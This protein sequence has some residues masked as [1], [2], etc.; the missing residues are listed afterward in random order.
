MDKQRKWIDVLWWVGLY[1]FWIIVFQK[2]AFALSRTVTVQF[3]YLLFIAANFYFNIYFT[4]PRFLYRKKYISFGFALAAGIIVA[5]LLRVPLAMFLNWNYFLVGLAQ[6][7]PGGLFLDSILNIFIW[8]AFIVSAKLVID[9]FRFQ[10]YVDKMEQERLTTELAFLNAQ[11]NPHFLFNS[12]NSIYGHIDKNN[13]S[14]RNMLL[15]FS[16]MLRYQLYECNTDLIPIDKELSYI[17][18]YIAL[19]QARKDDSLVVCL[20]IDKDVCGFSIAPLLFMAFIEN[21]FKYAGND[22][23]KENRI[24]ISFRKDGEIL[25]FTA[26]NT[27]EPD[28][29]NGSAHDLS[30]HKGIGIANVRRRLELLYPGKYHLDIRDHEHDFEIHLNLQLK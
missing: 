15:T 3:C 23:D 6:P 1:L 27:S 21:A 17:R 2:R 9:R 7:D 11:F 13:V 22:E 20:N 24:E 12:L 16:E 18:N 28:T 8:V 30:A 4:I 25:L 29:R 5:A 10:K 19:Q 26:F 14:A